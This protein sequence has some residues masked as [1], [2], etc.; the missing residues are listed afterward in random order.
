MNLDFQQQIPKDF[1]DQSKVWIYQSNRLFT[2]SE[3][4]QTEEILNDFISN[5]TSHSQNVKVFAKLFFDQ[6][7]VIMADE[8]TS[9]VG[10]CSI[11][12]AFR[13]IKE[14]EK[15]ASVALF[16]RQTLAL[17]IKDKIQL[18]PLSEFQHAAETKF[19]DADTLYFN[20]TVLTQKEL[21][22]D[23]IVPIKKSWLNKKI[24]LAVL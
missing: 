4:L 9:S 18:L 13:V 15:K 21:L 11:D 1:S 20:N 22:D 8:T 19:I 24:Q 17:V 7:I 2:I 6:F 16:D 5:W 3:A 14:I 10:G 23:W 12:S